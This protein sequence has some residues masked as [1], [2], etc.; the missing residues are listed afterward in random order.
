MITRNGVVYSNYSLF[1]ALN[2][3][4]LFCFAP[5]FFDMVDAKTIA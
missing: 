2:G 4:I 3:K 1:A 5:S